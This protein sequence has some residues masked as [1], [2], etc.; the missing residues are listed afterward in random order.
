[1]S[2]RGWS[3]RGGGGIPREIFFIVDQCVQSVDGWPTGGPDGTG[4]KLALFRGAERASFCLAFGGSSRSRLGCTWLCNGFWT[5]LEGFREP[6]GAWRSPRDTKRLV[7]FFAGRSGVFLQT[8]SA[9][10]GFRLC[11][12]VRLSQWSELVARRPEGWRKVNI[13]AGFNQVTIS[14]P[15]DAIEFVGMF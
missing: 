12:V 8:R 3:V 14:I 7:F 1:V 5:G 9:Y 6:G 10:K 13:Y 15:D 4:R 11:P 2:S